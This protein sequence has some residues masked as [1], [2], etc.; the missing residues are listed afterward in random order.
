VSAL[1]ASLR[2]L[3]VDACPASNAI[4]HMG[5]PRIPCAA[6]HNTHEVRNGKRSAHGAVKRRMRLC[7]S[8]R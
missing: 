8:V 1:L 3:A 2:V 4:G 7:A 6:Q 5:M